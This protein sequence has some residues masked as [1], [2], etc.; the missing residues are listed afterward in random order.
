MI[1]GKGQTEALI[2]SVGH[3]GFVINYEDFADSIAS[4]N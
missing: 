4:C 3:S 1:L 2:Y